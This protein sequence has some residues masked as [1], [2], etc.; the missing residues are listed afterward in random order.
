M[1]QMGSVM[2]NSMNMNTQKGNKMT[3]ATL[4]KAPEYVHPCELELTTIFMAGSIE[5]GK[6]VD[7]QTELFNR[8]SDLPIRYLNPRRDDW[9]SS[10]KQEIDNPQFNDQVT[11][12]LNGLMKLS[13]YQ[14]FVFDPAT[15][16][17]ITLLELGLV[18]PD[19]GVIG[20]VCPTGYFRKGNVDIV[21]KFYKVPVVETIAELEQ[22]IRNKLK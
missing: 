3:Q 1:T 10:W 2:V 13:E 5:M 22:L 16:S 12:E 15:I 18:A 7:W 14:I 21:C 17:P 8:T 9:D 11:W 20:V 4:L 6:A 19:G